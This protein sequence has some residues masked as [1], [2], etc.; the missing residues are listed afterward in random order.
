MKDEKALLLSFHVLFLDIHVSKWSQNPYV[1]GSWTDPVVGTSW[2]HYDNMAGRLK[3]LFF[4]GESTSGDYYG[5]VQGAYFTGRDKAN[6]IADCI[7]GVK[8]DEY[9]PAEELI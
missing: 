5:Y 7:N 3:N 8:C 9:E 4:A 1:G 6:E 2:G